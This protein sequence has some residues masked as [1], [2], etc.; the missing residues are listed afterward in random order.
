MTLIVILFEWLKY[1]L[2]ISVVVS[3]GCGLV[4]SGLLATMFGCRD[5]TQMI[6]YVN[7]AE[8][9]HDVISCVVV[10]DVFVV[11]TN[12]VAN[13]FILSLQCAEQ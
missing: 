12:L 1:D 10:V 2:Q 4:F 8:Q 9:V 7:S 3:L 6:S 5:F 13:D 11:Y